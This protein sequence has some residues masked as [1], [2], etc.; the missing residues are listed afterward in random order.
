MSQD[1]VEVTT[2]DSFNR[3]MVE[4]EFLRSS[5]DITYLISFNRYMVEC[6]CKSKLSTSAWHSCFNR[7]M[8]ECEFVSIERVIAAGAEF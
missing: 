5:S 4:C 6:E 3:Y 8:V 7:Y 2:K 1:K